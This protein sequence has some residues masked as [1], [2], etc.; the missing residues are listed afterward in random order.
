MYEYIKGKLI[1]SNTTSIVVD[2]NNIGY[3]IK[4][5]LSCFSD[6]P[7]IGKDV[8]IFLSMIVREDSHTLYGFLT[9]E[10]KDLFEKLITVS[11]IGPKVA[12]TL[13]GRLDIVNFQTAI[14][15]SDIKLLS[16]V[17]GIGKKT[18]Q[19]L[20]IELKDKIKI[21][22]DVSLNPQ[23]SINANIPSHANDAIKALINLGYNPLKAQRA[24][25][26]LAKE[27]KDLDTS[28]LIK[29]ALQNI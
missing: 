8:F 18:A 7:Q 27:N 6:L 9:K 3:K 17:P 15:N 10:K 29:A 22:G 16:K 12:I 14:I 1:T 13:L 2:A 5:S 25:Q 11:G 24:I 19:R 28:S 4:V 20:L 26:S 21:I 23:S